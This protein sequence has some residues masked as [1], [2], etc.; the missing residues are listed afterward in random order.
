[1]KQGCLE[2]IEETKHKKSLK[3][4]ALNNSII[5][6]RMSVSPRSTNSSVTPL[7]LPIKTP[8]ATQLDKHCEKLLMLSD[9]YEKQAKNFAA[10]RIKRSRAL[11]NTLN[12]PKLFNQSATPK[13]QRIKLPKLK[14]S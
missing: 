11:I 6:S 3:L 14:K 2:K 10:N 12:H 1:M 5:N 13:V 9:F 8:N 4:S 7:K